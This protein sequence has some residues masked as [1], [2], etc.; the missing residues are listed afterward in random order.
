MPI[1]QTQVNNRVLELTSTHGQQ[2][3]ALRLAGHNNTAKIAVLLTATQDALNS[4]TGD[5]AEAQTHVTAAMNLN[6]SFRTE[7][8]ELFTHIA[9]AEQLISQ[10]PDN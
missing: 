9:I 7:F 2:H 10:M 4:K 5:K 8:N 3:A 6:A 1:N